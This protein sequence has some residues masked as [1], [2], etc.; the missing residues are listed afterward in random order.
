[1]NPPRFRRRSPGRRREQ[2]LD[3]ANALFAQRAYEEVSIKDIADPVR[4]VVTDLV[5]RAG[6]L[7]AAFHA[8]IADDSP[9]LRHALACW[10]GLNPARDVPLAAQRCHPRGNARTA[11]L[12]PRARPGHVR[13]T[14]RP[15]GP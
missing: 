2:V 11:R 10:T 13:R 8:D 5:L 4:R 9:R 7:L 3:A 15:T 12:H 14:T 1:M 6:A